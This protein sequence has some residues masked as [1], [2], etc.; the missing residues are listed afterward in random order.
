ML[1]RRNGGAARRC[2]I[3]IGHPKTGSTY[4]QHCLHLNAAR[5]AA[6]KYWV[7]G[8]FRPFGFHDLALLSRQ[9]K[10]IS[11]NLGPMHALLT[12]G[13]GDRVAEMNAYLFGAPAGSD[14]LLSSEL[15]FYYPHCTVQIVAAAHGFGFA[16]EI[17]AYLPR[18]DRA[19][20]SSYLQN[21]RFHGFSE[22]VADFLLHDRFMRYCHYLPPIRALAEAAP[23]LRVTLRSFNPAFLR[24]GDLLA[25]F[26]ATAACTVDPRSCE[27]PPGQSNQGLLLEQYELL[28]AA[29]LLRREAAAD[30]LRH[31]DVRVTDADRARTFGF[32]Y[33]AAAHA[34]LADVV[35]PETAALLDDFMPHMPQQE[36]A[37]WD[38]IGPVAEP[39]D[40]DRNFFLSLQARMFGR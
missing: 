1:G 28:R 5:F 19:A 40:L 27:R 35:M 24:D 21:V 30:Q 13:P 14:I 23:G 17:V 20:V 8:D 7:P 34:Y 33:R 4:L 22:G 12:D 15:L 11:G 39:V 18:P 38:G 29:N 25:D 31:S 2:V 10:A 26:L 9:G 16:P 6:A 36:R 37:W 3:H 32:Y